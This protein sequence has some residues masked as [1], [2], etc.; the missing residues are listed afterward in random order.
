MVVIL[1]KFGFEDFLCPLAQFFV[2]FMPVFPLLAAGGVGRISLRP[3]VNAGELVDV[4]K[5]GVTP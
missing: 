2:A 3:V 4:Q 5:H 1:V